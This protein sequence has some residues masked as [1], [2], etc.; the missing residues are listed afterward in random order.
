[1]F[2]PSGIEP[3][4]TF[5]GRGQLQLAYR[6]QRETPFF[7]RLALDPR[8]MYTVR[9]LGVWRKPQIAALGLSFVPAIAFSGD[10]PVIAYQ[11]EGLKQIRRGS[12]KYLEDREGG[13]SSIGFA[14]LAKGAWNTGFISQANEIIVRDGSVVDGSVGRLY[15]MVEQKWRPRMA[16]DKHGV[17]WVFWPDTTRRHTYF[18]RWLGSRF[19]DAYECRGAYYAPSEYMTVEKHMPEDASEIGFAYAA[20]GRLFFGTVP[21]PGPS[22]SDS[23]HILFLDMLEIAEIE[24]LRQNLNQFSKDPKKPRVQTFRARWVG[25]LRR[26]VPKRSSA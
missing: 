4:F 26:H 11:H 2:A 17:P 23:R 16:V 3:V 5:D 12:A 9:E 25:R 20:A 24:G 1:M 14:T 18:A 21:V 10:R 8:I 22:T 13:G 15:P 7:G 6:L 19:S